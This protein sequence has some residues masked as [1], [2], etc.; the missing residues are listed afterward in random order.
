MWYEV[1]NREVAKDIISVYR[2]LGDT[3]LAVKCCKYFVVSIS[4]TCSVSFGEFYLL[5]LYSTVVFVGGYWST[6]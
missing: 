3:Y 5:L 4:V 6:S 1:S 2:H